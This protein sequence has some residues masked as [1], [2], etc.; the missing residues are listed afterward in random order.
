MRNYWLSE[1]NNKN[2]SIESDD[3]DSKEEPEGY[4]VK[5]NLSARQQK[6]YEYYEEVV[7]EFGM[8][9]QTSGAS[10]AHYAP[11]NANPF[12]QKGLVC[13]NCVYFIGGGACEIV[14]GRI[15]SDAICKLW[16]IPED[17]IKE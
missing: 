7:E 10:G 11:A 5:G 13:S 14:A 6:L 12:K 15:E 8:F 4:D 17:L 3:D 1:H 9:D 2:I 16:I